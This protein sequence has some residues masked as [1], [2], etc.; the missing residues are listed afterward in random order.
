MVST[1]K[2]FGFGSGSIKDGPWTTFAAKLIK[3]SKATVVPIHFHGRNSR[4]F[5]IASHIALP[6][7]TGLLMHEALNKF[8]SSLD[9]T[10]GDPIEWANLE[11]YEHRQDLTDAL[12]AVVQNLRH[13]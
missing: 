4:K 9:V 13:K 12:Y 1:A 2:K 7:R 10:I 6:L 5:H 8:G 11:R 3:Q